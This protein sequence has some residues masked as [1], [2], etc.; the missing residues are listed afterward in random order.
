MRTYLKPMLLLLTIAAVSAAVQAAD[1][2]QPASH[3]DATYEEVAALLMQESNTRNEIEND[4][5]T[6][7]SE[8]D[9]KSYLQSASIAHTPSASFLQARS[10]NSSRA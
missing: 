10:G 7:R 9:L 8:A 6:I 5:A 3:D 4:M 2:A 1:P